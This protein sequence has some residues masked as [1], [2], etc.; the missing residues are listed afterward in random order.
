[1]RNIFLSVLLVVFTGQII[2]QNKAQITQKILSYPETFNSTFS[3]VYRIKSDFSTDLDRT[4]AVY[5]WITNNI[6]YDYAAANAYSGLWK[7]DV[8]GDPDPDHYKSIANYTFQYRIAVCEGSSVLFN[9]LCRAMDIQVHKVVG[10]ART[11]VSEIGVPWNSNHAW[12]LVVLDDQQFLV[13]STWGAGAWKNNGFVKNPNDFYF[14]TPPELFIEKHYPEDTKYT[15][16]NENPSK[17]WFLEKAIPQ[18]WNNTFVTANLPKS[19]IIEKPSQGVRELKFDL[20]VAA[21]ITRVSIL[22][23]G[24]FIPVTNY[25]HENGRL[26][27]THAISSGYLKN[28]LL[29]YINNKAVLKYRVVE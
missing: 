19:G 28:Q 14:M 1:M 15:L 23:N 22:N 11:R 16:L 5:S 13:D 26:T 4:Y 25:V 17:S 10:C 20:N 9:E 18:T 2:G 6:A 24:E 27:F 21:P 7:P 8:N 12:N 3:L 29:V